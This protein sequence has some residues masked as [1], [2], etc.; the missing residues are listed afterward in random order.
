MSSNVF[1]QQRDGAQSGDV[2]KGCNRPISENDHRSV[3]ITY[4]DDPKKNK[5]TRDEFTF[6]VRIDGVR[7]N[8]VVLPRI[9]LTDIPRNKWSDLENDIIKYLNKKVSN[10]KVIAIN[11]G[12]RIVN[13]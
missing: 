5:I 7:K 12:Y 6:L 2:F 1:E 3:Y 9:T 10:G 13:L 8:K 4:P 11:N